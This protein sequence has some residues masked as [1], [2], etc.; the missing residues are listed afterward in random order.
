GMLGKISHTDDA[1]LNNDFWHAT[2][3]RRTRQS[4]FEELECL[5]CSWPNKT[6]CHPVILSQA[7]RP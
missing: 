4:F 1:G 2:R 3:F 7:I 6:H 5:I